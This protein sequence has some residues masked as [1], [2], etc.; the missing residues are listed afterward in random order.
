MLKPF[1]S[2]AEI[3]IKLLKIKKD[4]LQIVLLFKEIIIAARMIGLNVRRIRTG[5][6][7]SPDS[8]LA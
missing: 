7:S 1:Y 3:L 2:P 5:I 4:D 6:F 8:Y